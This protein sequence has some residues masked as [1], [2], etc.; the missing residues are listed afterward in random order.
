MKN[1]FYLLI[2]AALGAGGITSCQN[3]SDIYQDYIV[4]GGVKYPQKPDSLKVHA[5]YNKLTLTWLKSKDPSVVSAT[6]SWN[7]YLNSLDVDLTRVQDELVSVDVE[8]LEEGNYTFYVQTFDKNG[9]VSIISEASGSAYGEK[10]VMGLVDRAINSALRDVNFNGT[11]EWGVKTT[12]LVYSEV[13]YTSSTGQSRT[14][15]LTADETR[16]ICPG[17]KPGEFFEYRSCFLPPNG[18]DTVRLPWK[19]FDK[20]FMYKYPRNTWTGVAKNGNH[21][22]GDGGGGPVNLL[23]DGNTATGWHSTVGTPFPNCVVVDMKEPLPVDHIIITPPGPANWRYLKDIVV[24]LTDTEID[25][26]D[27][28]LVSILETLT[29]AAQGTYDSSAAYTLQFPSPQTGRFM[30]V[31]FPNYSTSPYTSFMELEVLGY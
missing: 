7:N 1:L 20:P 9:N 28:N 5:G 26:N 4:P 24:Y 14:A 27:G 3:Q 13:R 15:R 10:Y 11:V 16:L 6:I 31:S 21:N 19:T 29:P 8:N 22:W 12:D 18:V 17:I 23:F 2:L 30:T 25:P